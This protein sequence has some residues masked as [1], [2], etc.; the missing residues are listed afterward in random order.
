MVAS[1]QIFTAPSYHGAGRAA[2]AGRTTPR[3]AQQQSH[4]SPSLYKQ[5]TLHVTECP[6]CPHW[7][8]QMST[9]YSFHIIQR[10]CLVLALAGALF[11]YCENYSKISS[12]CCVYPVHVHGSGPKCGTCEHVRG[13]G[14]NTGSTYQCVSRLAGGR[15][16][17]GR[18]QG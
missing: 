6:E 15:E 7:T 1:G 14:T 3:R 12:P 11:Q 18:L 13:P 9:K 5:Q 8:L 2:A 17:G 4:W 16:G 10:W